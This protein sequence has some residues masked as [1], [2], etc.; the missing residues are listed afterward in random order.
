[1]TNSITKVVMQNENKNKNAMTL[2]L[3]LWPSLEY[4]KERTS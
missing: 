4:C 2:T 3:G 1:V